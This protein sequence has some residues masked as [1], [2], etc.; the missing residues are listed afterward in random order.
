M[1]QAQHT[2]AKAPAAAVGNGLAKGWSPMHG[3]GH[4]AQ[5]LAHDPHDDALV[6]NVHPTDWTN[7]EPAP[8]YNLVVIG[9]GTAGLVTAAGAA[10]LGAKVAL[11]E[12][13]LMGGD[14]LNVGCV[15]SK[16]VIRSSRV[17]GDIR[18][19]ERFGIRVC[20]D[21]EVDF[22]AVMER[23]RR[24]R[25]GISHHDSAQ[26]FQQEL[27]VDV[28]LGDGRFSG[29]DTIEVAGK[30]LHFKRAVIASGAR[31]GHPPI[32]G[33]AEA[34]FLT[35]ETVFSLTERPR[36]L[37]V[38]GGGPI[39]CELAQAFRRL[40]C[41]VVLF[42]NANHILNREDADAAE[43]VQQTF[44]REGI[45]LVL[46]SE[47]QHVERTANGKVLH[48]SS[49]GKA[50]TITVD[51]IL[52]GTGRA[53]NV[54]GLNLET[55]GVQYD[56][57]HGVKVNDR[58]QTTN[59]R[60]YA[61]GDICMDYKFT[62]AADF[63]ARLV[64]QNTLFHGKK[65]LSTLTMPWC[66]YTDPEIAHVGM[67]EREAR[68]KGIALDTFTISMNQ[69]DRAIADGEE[70]GFVKVHVK[71]GTDQI[72]GATI[73]ARHA[74]EMISEITLAMVGKL[75]L[76]TLASVIHPYPTQAEA[77]RKVGDGY[78]RTRLTPFVKRVFHRWLAWTR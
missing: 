14:C 42:H 27:G 48:F 28:F 64:I 68:E 31:A 19:A 54:E 35:N 67:Y 17:V 53:P 38:I 5:L 72:L 77:I 41:E 43:I 76:S 37:A 50:D 4:G 45:R 22:P 70:D 26:R 56:K 63:A 51:D 57:K 6:A 74:G 36:R 9:A 23:M 61:A 16:C 65:K 18:D 21:V 15:P 59:P 7:P 73:V 40:G 52:V 49:Q 33:L 11:V 12:R 20:G 47:V 39:G 2:H 75:G 55:V 10:G 66:T 34:G 44:I 60:I 78:N 29:P 69:V 3:N 32:P 30:T 46:D 8:R 58:L 24:L 25:A 13:H 71:K 62:H 1:N